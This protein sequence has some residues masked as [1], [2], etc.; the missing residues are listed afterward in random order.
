M[1]APP[2]V[3]GC[4]APAAAAEEVG[5]PWVAVPAHTAGAT[6][7]RF[8]V[9]ARRTLA[10]RPFAVVAAR[11]T[12]VQRRGIVAVWQQLVP[13]RLELPVAR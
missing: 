11:C 4:M 3:G 5:A 10:R 2:W 8:D 6:L 9:R 1:V 12:L 7:W 13:E